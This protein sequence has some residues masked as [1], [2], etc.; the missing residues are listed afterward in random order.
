ME[1]LFFLAILTTTILF[2]T[3]ITSIDFNQTADAIKSKGNSRTEIGSDKVCGDSLCTGNDVKHTTKS[4]DSMMYVDSMDI[5]AMMERMDKVHETHQQQ[6][7]QHWDSMTI[8]EQSQMYAH[9]QQMIEKMESM[10]MDDHMQMMSN[11]GMESHDKMGME[12]HDQDVIAK[13]LA[14]Q[15]LKTFDEL[16]FDVFTNQ[17]WDRLLE[18]HSKDIIVHWPD[19]VQ[20]KGIE[21]HIDDLK[22]MFVYAPDTRIQEHPVKIASG[23]W[24]S[25]IGVM[26]GTFTKPMPLP[27]GTM[28]PPTGKS[29][30]LQMVT[31]GHWSDGVMDEEYLFW[32][33]QS[34]MK[35]IGLS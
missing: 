17:K 10:S 23:E 4:P 7:I 22:S 29:F 24:T 1:K 33:N 21:R 34:F 9:M 25:V 16:D 31:V 11:M 5:H 18:S 8:E 30:K 12:S 2:T 20:T 6:M 32:D 13:N 35:Q 27:D 3:S 28:I 15:H 19:G 26:E 14:I